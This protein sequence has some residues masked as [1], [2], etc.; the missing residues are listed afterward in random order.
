MASKTR[1]IVSPLLFGILTVI[2][3]TTFLMTGCSSGYTTVAPVPGYEQIN[4]VSDTA[5]YGSA[6][7]DANLLNAW[8]IA[9]SP[10]GI[11][12]IAANHSGT[13]IIYDGNGKQVLA[14]V[15]IPLGATPHGSSPS[16]VIFNNTAD[17]AIPNNGV[18][19][20]IFSTED[21][22]ISA[23]N[24][25]TGATTVTVADRSSDG[26][27]YKG[28]AMAND[29]GAA[30]IYVTDFHN[31]KIDVFDNSFALV[32]TKPF[33]DPGIPAGFA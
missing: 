23:W 1:K 17:F 29:G 13:G 5:G 2:H 14:P 18:S 28:L 8:G 9:I 11:F 22:I 19:L 33:N 27:V 4:L 31:G 10:S 7:I 20:F 6:R 3:G 16:G 15:S 30:F 25:A 24:D 21:G 12:W 26:A 32:T